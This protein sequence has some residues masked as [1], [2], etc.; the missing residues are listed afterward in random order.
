MKKQRYRFKIATLFLFALFLLLG[1]YGI[2]SV[3]HF[4]S[5][6]F[7]YAANPRLAAQK[8]SVI[9]GD[10]LDRSGTVLAHTEDG[11][12]VFQETAVARR[13]VVHV[14]GDRFGMVA[15][16]VESFEAGYLYGYRS[17]LPDAIYHLTHSAEPRKGNDVTLTLSGELCTAIPGFFEKHP[18]SAGKNGAAV[19]LNYETGEVIAL[20]SLPSFDPDHA[21]A[22]SIAG[23]DHPYWNRAT[24]GLYPPG[25]TFKII[26][27]AAALEKMAGADSRT[28]TCTGS[29]PVT[30][31]FTVQD[32]NQAV[33]G[34]L[35]L[36]QAFLRSC[37]SVFASLALEMGDG[38]LR[39]TAEAFGFNMNFLF[40]DLVVYN[41]VYPT[42][43][44]TKA[45]VAASGYGQSAL[46][47]TP[48]HMCLIAAAVAGDGNM[49]EPRLLQE[50]RSASGVPVLRFSSARACTVCRTATAR[51]L[52]DMM[53]D[54]VQG[55]GSGYLAAVPTLDVR[56]KTGTAESTLNGEKVNYAWFTG[57][58]AQKD[59]PF[60][61]CVLV[62]GIPDGE[63]GGTAAAPIVKDILTWLKN[64]PDKVM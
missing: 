34:D 1:A 62:E 54:V 5:R 44:R 55:G 36:R 23:L 19:V 28:Y 51:S 12:R 41:S 29:F 18:L 48:L 6:W 8:A 38:A 11:K 53:K 35:S 49:P 15:N 22:A 24:Q 46:A 39:Q 10:I 64:H 56:G 32:F 31:S 30:D 61:V 58:N 27:A 4:G 37:N 52:Q 16:S 7:S 21:D 59:L 45:A 42:A 3:S 2:W 63:T 43:G 25:S 14:I 20:V 57:Y 17:S 47:A 60:A 40:R 9:E 50:V 13:A 26:T 33:H